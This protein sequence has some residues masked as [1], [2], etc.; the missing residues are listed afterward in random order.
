M[1][2]Y[3]REAIGMVK[4]L[5]N[6]LVQILILAT[7]LRFFMLGS[8]PL[9][10]NWDEVSQGYTAYSIMHTGAD[11]WGMKLP[12]FFRSYGEW[13]SAVY[14]YGGSAQRRRVWERR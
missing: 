9:S 6:R 10:L 2:F 13:K 12:L 8:A 5:K 7:A 3:L 4:F 11:E 14:I 1:L